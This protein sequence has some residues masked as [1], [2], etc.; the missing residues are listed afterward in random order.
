M[1]LEQELSDGRC[2]VLA[3]EDL[4]RQLCV[5]AG[6][7]SEWRAVDM[8]KLEGNLLQSLCAIEKAEVRLSFCP[9]C[10]LRD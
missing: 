5:I 1:F 8:R 10:H 2:W 4:P 3:K 7:L 9:H 6:K